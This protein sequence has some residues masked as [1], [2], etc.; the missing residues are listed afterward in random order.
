MPSKLKVVFFRTASKAEPVRDWLKDQPKED[1]RTIGSDIK[2]VQFGWPIGMPVVRKIENRLWEVRSR[3]KDGIVR[4]FFTVE[5]EFMV[6][7][8]VFKKKTT[9]TPPN[10]LKIARKR[11]KEYHHEN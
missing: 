10:E 7:L 4:T 8:H 2:T 5:E 9:K 11:M 3:V 6:L 1:M